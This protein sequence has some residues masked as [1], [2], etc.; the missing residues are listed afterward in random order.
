M[1]THTVACSVCGG[2]FHLNLAL[3]YQSGL[4]ATSVIDTTVAR[5]EPLL[6]TTV[7]LSWQ[8]GVQVSLYF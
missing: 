4:H 8:E 7:I 5:L 6:A 2:V 1:Y 3:F